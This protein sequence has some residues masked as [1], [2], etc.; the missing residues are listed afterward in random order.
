MNDEM[1]IGEALRREADAHPV[2][3]APVD[4][5]LRRG[6]T[7]RRRR[8]AAT[9]GAAVAT[10]ALALLAYGG[11]PG[12]DPAPAPTPPATAGPRPVPSVTCP[13]AGMRTV[14]P[15]EVVDIGRGVRMALLPEGNQN[16]V[17][18]LD[19]LQKDI[20]DARQYPGTNILPN[21]LSGSGGSDEGLVAGAFRTDEVPARIVVR[22]DE[23]GECSAG[24]LRLRGEAGWGT[25][26]AFLDASTVAAGYTVTAFAGDGGVLAQN[27]FEP[28]AN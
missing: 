15:Y 19:D 1:R 12:A 6:R 24:V 14:Q 9:A 18:G 25:Y 11:V 5:V 22:A 13:R 26:Y 3:Q 23:G 28:K 20:D 10:A 8:T 7:A 17:V 27:H 21:S 2:G 4:E 16:Y